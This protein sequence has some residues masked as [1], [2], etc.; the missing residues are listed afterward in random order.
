MSF[1]EWSSAHSAPAKDKPADKSKD[2]PAAAQPATQ[3]DKT[4]AEVA[5][6]PKS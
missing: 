4:Q 1:K 3:P 6:A 2:A 5:P